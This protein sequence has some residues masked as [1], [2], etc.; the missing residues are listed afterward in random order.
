MSCGA[1]KQ[2]VRLMWADKRDPP[3]QREKSSW[4]G[5]ERVTSEHYLPE[6]REKASWSGLERV[7]SERITH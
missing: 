4:S 2:G 1:Q 3:E 7:T 5:L 6:Q